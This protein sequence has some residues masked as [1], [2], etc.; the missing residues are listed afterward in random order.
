MNKK[1]MKIVLPLLALFIF[2]AIS[3]NMVFATESGTEEG[4]LS[5]SEI[6][7][8]FEGKKV[9]ILGDSIST[10][11]GVSNNTSYN[12]T[13]GSNAYYYSSGQASKWWQQVIDVLGM[14][15]CVNN[16]W[17]G[18]M[19]LQ[20]NKGTSEN[21]SAG[22]VTRCVNLHN[23][24]GEEDVLP[25]VIW[26]FLGTN[27][28]T[29][30]RSAMGTFDAIDYESLIV[31]GED[32]SYSYAT[33]TTV[34]EAYAIMLHKMQIAYPEAEIYC[35]NLL[36]RRDPVLEGKTNAGQPTVFNAELAKVVN[37]AGVKLVDLEN[38][39][40]E[41]DPEIYDNYITDQNV[42]PGAKGM[43]LM[44]AALL[45]EMIGTD[46]HPVI[47]N[48]LGTSRSN[49]AF[50]TIDGNS[51]STDINLN[52]AYENLRV[53]VSM[54][55]V[56]I[57]D[58]V[59]SEGTVNIPA[60]TGHVVIEA[61]AEV[62]YKSHLQSL[63]ENLC[64]GTNLWT[65]LTPERKSFTND[66]VWETGSGNTHSITFPVS[67]GDQI[68]ATSFGAAGANGNTAGTNGIRITWFLST[69]GFKS[70]APGSTY[71]EFTANGCMTAPE[72]A[73]AV[74]IIQWT[75][76]TTN[77]VYILNKEHNYEP[78]TTDA[79]YKAYVCTICGDEG[80]RI[81]NTSFDGAVALE[82][83]SIRLRSTETATNGLRS[84]CSFDW[85]KNAA[86]EADGYSLL[87]FG[88][89]A[90]SKAQYEAAGNTFT[91]DA[92]SGKLSGV[93]GVMVPVWEEGKFVGKTLGTV[94]NVTQFALTAVN[95]TDNYTSDIYFCAYSVYSLAGEDEPIVTIADYPVEGYEFANIYQ[96]T[97]DM[98]IN[99]AINASNTDDTAVWDTLL[100]GVVTL[101]SS[102]YGT[103]AT[104]MDGNAFGDSFVFKDV[105]NMSS[106]NVVNK[107]IKIT[108]L[109]DYKNS[110]YVAVFRGTGNIA[111]G[112]TGYSQFYHSTART[113]M[114]HPKLTEATNKKISTF[115]WDKGITGTNGTYSLRGSYVKTIVCA[116]TVVN[117]GASTFYQTHVLTSVYQAKATG[118]MQEN[119]VGLVDLS[120]ITS[121]NANNLMYKLSTSAGVKKVH[122]PTK[123][124]S[125]TLGAAFLSYGNATTRYKVTKVWCGNTPEPAEGVVDLSGAASLT[126]LKGS[127]LSALSKSCASY[128][129][130]LPDSCTY[131]TDICQSK[132]ITEVRQVN[133][134]P[135]LAASLA[136]NSYI[137]ST[138]KYCDLSGKEWVAPTE[139][140]TLRILAIGNSFSVDA[141][142]W[143]YNIAMDAKEK[144]EVDYEYVSLGNLYIGGCSL[145]TH[146]SNIQN[147]SGSYKYY[148]NSNGVWSSTSSYKLSA[149][150]ASQQ[151]DIITVQQA[152]PNSGQPDTFTNLGNILDYVNTNKTNEN[153]KIYWHMTWAYQGNSSHSGFSNYGKDQTTMYNAITDTVQSTVLANNSIEGVIP[154]G[155]AIQNARSSYIGDTLTRDGYHLSYGLGR[156]IAGMTWFAYLTGESIENITWVPDEYKSVSLYLD[157]V[158]EA[159]TNAIS[160]PYEVTASTY[161]E[162][163]QYTDE[164]LFTL[165]GLEFDDYSALD[166][167]D[168]TYF[169]KYYQSENYTPSSMVSGSGTAKK[170]IGIGTFDKTTLPIGSVLI[171][172]TGYQ[173]RPE[174]WVDEN[175]T[176]S[177][178][179][180]NVTTNFVITDEDWWG[181]YT[182]RGFNLAFQGAGSTVTMDVAEHFRIYIP[183]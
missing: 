138:A 101:E 71:S 91:V 118:V 183:S 113:K 79:G 10:L 82:G 39:G 144:G 106:G 26:V 157:V 153:A 31:A 55:G 122:L 156:Y 41:T 45:S 7:A 167:T 60:V 133:Y 182:I 64:K 148:T 27:D 158:K 162:E 1:A 52:T 99:G 17:S 74:N 147:D 112:S 163:P 177:S 20:N 129:L 30:N 59:Y 32:G 33:P 50:Y 172:D 65:A 140:N 23:D 3:L 96:L 155:T 56:D 159:V 146:W 125:N 11:K 109:N 86:F 165:Y 150:L 21:N 128:T 40:L 72:N 68:W 58:S 116:D 87:E 168:Y 180:D 130:I 151:W 160:A 132:C 84:I 15:L 110:T 28:F 115:I 119:E 104:D 5:V 43:D 107:N 169:Q 48:S 102:E 152:S 54:D 47:F 6:M 81:F 164:Q 124:T 179:P 178:R 134:N 16:S 46:F 123:F 126:T 121:L 53:S 181:T 4:S 170:Y 18:S 67:G 176:N 38:C 73:V 98:Y 62:Q 171:L 13:I 77:E 14:E 149:A 44:S 117:I 127:T 145:D 108:L 136:S 76:D 105:Y 139:E 135:T 137:G 63:P 75:A 8:S 143:L 175:T 83:Y 37:K 120:F 49:T 25:D 141:M 103:G 142:Q 57:T 69:G 100:A 70:I 161:T 94:N 66:Y 97:L 85:S 154:S 12:S 9:S 24:T 78:A 89:I 111:S 34:F 93:S 95:F 90:V 114:S 51:Y 35:L 173:Y 80:D 92:E 2:A 61:E 174:G 131:I 29:H 88:A 36:V 42:H 19:I 22:Y 166:L